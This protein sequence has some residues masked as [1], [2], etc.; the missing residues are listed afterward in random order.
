QLVY[1]LSVAANRTIEALEIAV[2]DEDEVVEFLARCQR[3]LCAERLGFVRLT[4]ADEGPDFA[5]RL[6]DDAS[7]LQIPHETRLIDGVQRAEYHGNSREGPE[8]WHEPWMRI[9]GKP[10]SA[11]QFVAKIYYLLLAQASFQEG[12]AVDSGRGMA[13]KINK[14]AGLAG[15]SRVEKVVEA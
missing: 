2:D 7:V 15:V 3:E 11:A 6:R 9:R 14:I 13:L 8:A 1:D 10:G 4:V 12:A 5:W